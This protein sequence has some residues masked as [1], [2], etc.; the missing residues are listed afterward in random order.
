MG[1]TLNVV[2]CL[3]TGNS[4]NG[5]GGGGIGGAIRSGQATLNLTDSTFDGNQA[6]MEAGAVNMYQS[7]GTIQGCTFI[8]NTVTGQGTG[9][10]ALSIVGSSAT[11]AVINSTFAN[12][13]SGAG[14]GAIVSVFPGAATINASF[15]NDTIVDNRSDTADTAG[16]V[17]GGG[18]FAFDG[19]QSTFQ[20]T[21]VADNVAGPQGSSVADD[22]AT[23]DTSSF[24]SLGTN[25]FGATARATITAPPL[26]EADLTGEPDLQLLA[27]YGGPTKTLLPSPGSP[28]IDAGNNAGVP[29]G[30]MFDQRGVG[31]K[32]IA[33]S[34]VDI[35]ADEF[36]QVDPTIT[37]T[38]AGGVYNGNS[39][40]ATSSVTVGGIS[41]GSATINYYLA[42]DTSFAS[43]LAGTPTD[44]GDY[45]AVASFKGITGVNS[46]SMQTS[47]SITAATPKVTVNPVSITFG[48][49]LADGQLSGSA[50]FVINGK[51]VNVSGTYAY[52]TIGSL[53]GAGTILN[54]GDNQSENVVFTPNSADYAAVQTT[55]IVNVAQAM[56]TVSVSDAGGVFMGAAYP[57]TGSVTGVM[58]ADLGSP[59]FTY[60]LAS[61][62]SFTSPVPGAAGSRRELCGGR[63][64][65]PDRQLRRRVK[66]RELHNQ[67]SHAD[68]FR[69]RRWRRLHRLGVSGDRIGDRRD[70][71]QS[72]TIDGYV[73]PCQ[74]YELHQPPARRSG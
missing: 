65:R 33:N 63:E 72:R 36:Q 39:Y 53:T 55:T 10:G 43:P 18:V 67:S 40:P 8:N 23:H 59:T 49:A 19:T 16:S 73:L 20:N 24:T 45:V 12:N 25:L 41:V 9:G 52:G 66:F 35:G 58:G 7:S 3:F 28:V 22:L 57:A 29:A 32:R 13:A 44:V 30:V 54:A 42:S 34:K 6:A 68:G 17:Q 37:V 47:F 69:L 1:A 74:R 50:T 64:L 15:T 56:P 70:G 5:N 11:V 46:G 71:H 48:T 14:G 2:D 62:T 27:N 31:F 60:Y 51:T 4:C 38:D 26:N 21:I 61:D